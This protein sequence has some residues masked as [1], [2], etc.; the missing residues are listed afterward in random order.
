MEE[1]GALTVAPVRPVILD[2]WRER[3][4]VMDA[5]VGW[6]GGGQPRLPRHRQRSDGP[7][8][9]QAAR[10]PSKVKLRPKF[11]QTAVAYR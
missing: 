7:A 6:R 4:W 9:G 11:G 10:L 2:R 5:R 1:R 3:R 8:A